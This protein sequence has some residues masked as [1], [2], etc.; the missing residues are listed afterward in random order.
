MITYLEH[1]P[2]A[3]SEDATVWALSDGRPGNARQ[4][5]ALAEALAPGRAKSIHL[6]PRAPWRWASPYR[7]PGSAF[8]FGPEF[9]EALNH[10]PGLAIGCGRQ[11]AL[12]TRL[13]RTAGSRAVHI[14]DPRTARACWDMLIIPAHDGIHGENVII[15]NGS[16]NPV[17]DAWLAA[18]RADFAWIGR[19]PGPRLGVLVGGDSRHGKLPAVTG[20]VLANLI[21][22][23]HDATGG[24]VLA[25]TSR[26]TPA[27]LA[28]RLAQ[29]FRRVP[30]LCWTGPSDGANPYPG[31]LAFADRIVCSADSVNLLS[32][33]CATR[34]PVHVTG[35]D[36]MGD[37]RV[38]FVRGLFA[39][40]RVHAL[41]SAAALTAPAPPMLPLRETA[42]IAAIV[43]DRLGAIAS[44][45]QLN[46]SHS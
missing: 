35:M 36:A 27:A 25:T 43:R 19:V 34:V 17:D 32:E 4:A 18:A 22:H 30:G 5:E 12:A 37:R 24:S 16:L 38:K 44:S 28:E 14:L 13:L 11:A 40:G 20:E 31:I 9:A 41:E 1:T 42:R 33:A 26:R 3:L 21:H 45:T 29:P 10:P 6:A 46:S 8:A 7:L 15:A 23:W 2:S 39:S